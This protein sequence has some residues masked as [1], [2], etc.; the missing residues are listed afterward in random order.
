MLPVGTAKPSVL[1][2]TVSLGVASPPPPPQNTHAIPPGDGWRSN[3]A[4]AD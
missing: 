1:L 3:N 2:C 4:A